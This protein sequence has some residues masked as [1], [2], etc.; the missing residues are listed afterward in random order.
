MCI[1]YVQLIFRSSIS[2]RIISSDEKKVCFSKKS[3]FLLFSMN[4]SRGSR[5]VTFYL[6]RKTDPVIFQGLGLK[7]V[8]KILKNT[9]LPIEW[10][11]LPA[12]TS[13]QTHDSGFFIEK[14]LERAFFLGA[15]QIVQLKIII[16]LNA[17]MVILHEVN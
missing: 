13:A 2:Y 5:I 16:Y 9:K 7:K 17:C 14:T 15:Y 3:H 10:T 12:F 4:V 11:D 1:R 8:K 6:W